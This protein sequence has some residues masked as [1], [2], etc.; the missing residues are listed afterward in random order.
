MVEPDDRNPAGSWLGRRIVEARRQRGWTRE[1]L[2][3]R[4]D[5]SRTTLHHLERGA[6]TRPRADTLARLATALGLVPAEL[7]ALVDSSPESGA[8]AFDRQT[9]SAIQEVFDA[10]PGL[11]SG[12]SREDWDELCSTFG[13][14]G[15]LNEEGIRSEAERINRRRETID[16]LRLVMET[17]LA[18]VAERMVDTLYDMVAARPPTEPP[19][20]P[21]DAN[22]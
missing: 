2:A 15:R 17:H 10:S 9:N 20:D 22:P 6:T 1:E 7:H 12:W 18:D 4:A 21:D 11:F 3:Q 14:G 5:V 16:R 19:A 8:E 13:T